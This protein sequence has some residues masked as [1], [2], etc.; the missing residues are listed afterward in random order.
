MVDD[1]PINLIA[2]FHN[3]QMALKNM[4]RDMEVL[5]NLV[6]KASDGT[7]AVEMFKS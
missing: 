7:E 1:E 3:L 6:D 4:G 2:L 5:K